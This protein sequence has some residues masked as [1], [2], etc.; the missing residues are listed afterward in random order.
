MSRDLPPLGSPNL[1]Q[2]ALIALPIAAVLCLAQ[3]L[4]W[5]DGVE[6]WLIDLRFAV[7]GPR[8]LADSILIVA[9][10]DETVNRHPTLP[11]DPRL[12]AELIRRLSAAGVAAI[13]LDLPELARPAFDPESAPANDVQPYRDLTAALSES[14]RV[15]L[16]VVWVSGGS[17][18]A[19]VP[20]PVARSSVGQG[21]L[22][23]PVDLRRPAMLHPRADLCAAAA[24]LGVLNVHPDRDWTVRQAPLL[25][26]ASGRLYPSL[27]LEVARVATGRSVAATAAPTGARVS[28]GSAGI[29][30]NAAGEVVVNYAGPANT[31]PMLSYQAVIG[32]SGLDETTAASLRG[33]VVLVGATAVAETSR[34]RTPYSPFMTGVELNANVL[35]TVLSGRAIT[36]PRVLDGVLL[37]LLAAGLAAAAALLLRPRRAAL[38]LSLLLGGLAAAAVLAFAA[39]VCVPTAGPLLALGLIGGTLT[40]LRAAAVQAERRRHGE[41]IRS[42]MS[43]LAGVG[44]LLNS[45]LDREQLLMEIMLWVEE[46]IGCEAASLVLRSEAD[47]KLRFEV[48]LGPKAQEIKNVQIDVGQGIVGTVVATGEPLVVPDTERDPRFAKEIAQAV[49]FPAQSILCVPMS[50]R[51]R[52][53]GAIEVIN[54]GDG[55]PFSDH[56]TA[57]LTVIAQHAAMFLETARLYGVLEARVD[58]ANQELR[59]ANQQLGAEKAKLEAIVR[60]MADGIIAADEQ[61]RIVLINRAAEEMLGVGE[62]ALFGA[63]AARA[64]ENPELSELFAAPAE[65]LPGDRELTLGEPEQRILRVRPAT[66]ADEQGIAGR[67]VVMNDITDLRELDRTKTDMVS[68]VSHELKTPLAAIKGF[69]GLLRDRATAAD[70]RESADVINRQA[71]RMYRLI[72]DFL[73]IARIDMGRA[74]EVRWEAISDVRPIVQDAVASQPLAGPAHRF[75]VDVPPD[76][77]PLHADPHKLYHVLLNLINN[78]VKY[79][80]DGGEVRVSVAAEDQGRALHFVV[81][82]EGIGIRPDNM[83]HLFKRF[84]RVRDGSGDRIEGTGLGLFLTRHLV[85][86]HGGRTWAESEPGHG[87]T[88]HFVLPTEGRPDDESDHQA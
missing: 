11:A 25:L 87:S 64:L 16:P 38:A 70:T 32:G 68:F 76:L 86:A 83:Q 52:V 88:F 37:T 56:D 41:R 39:G 77:P 60:H 53:I 55:T 33:K 14:G 26:E 51:D 44:R 69:A 57:L 19:G 10:D 8:S 49:G 30:A 82:D 3:P 84:R 35:D 18:T 46:E 80:P 79:S 62:Q 20:A 21:E 40:T 63:P 2:A 4:R 48:A 34:L 50:V 67:V 5:L 28:L 9:I 65:D 22:L 78:A 17:A 54:K 85:E 75:A 74:L 31:Y 7:R 59:V 73:N 45:G 36:Q 61:G 13:G 12:H 47:G 23:Q 42:R 81:R 27:A 24:G 29:G 15:V 58:L 72:D 71:E 66:V 1:R 43:T 6:A